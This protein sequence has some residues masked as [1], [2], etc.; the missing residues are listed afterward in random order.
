VY[1][2]LKVS[3]SAVFGDLSVF[4]IVYSCILRF[5]QYQCRRFVHIIRYNAAAKYKIK[6]KSHK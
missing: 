3:E 2:M 4:G 6:R 1:K 5:V